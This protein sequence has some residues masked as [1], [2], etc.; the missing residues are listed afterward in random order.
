M[1][2]HFTLRMQFGPHQD[3]SDITEQLLRLVREAPVDEIMFFYFAEE[4]NDGH[5]TLQRVRKW[6]ERS[7]PYRD[8]L[9]RAGVQVSLNPWQT[10]L[11][12]DRGRTLKREQPWQRMVDP[13]GDEATAVVCPLDAA[14]RNYY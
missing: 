3:P 6:I 13:A 9:T 1:P 10:L 11:H 14:W 5:E 4:Q 2:S 7:R 8:A 12:G